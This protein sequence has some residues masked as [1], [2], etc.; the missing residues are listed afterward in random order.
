MGGP[1]ALHLQLSVVSMGGPTRKKIHF[2]YKN[3]RNLLFSNEKN[4]V[5]N[6]LVLVLIGWAVLCRWFDETCRWFDEVGNIFSL[7]FS[8]SLSLSLT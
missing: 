7:S 6:L 2:L 4:Y 8:L 1:P 5:Y 3:F